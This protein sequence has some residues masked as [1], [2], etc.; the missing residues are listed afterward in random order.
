M[1][2]SVNTNLTTH[3][4]TYAIVNAMLRECVNANFTSAIKWA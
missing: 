4:V 2:I 1:N 3:I